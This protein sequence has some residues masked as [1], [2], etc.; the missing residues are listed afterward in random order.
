MIK[1]ELMQYLDKNNLINKQQH[2]FVSNKACNTNLLETIDLLT[3]LLVDKESFDLLLLDFAK[4]FDVVSHQRLLIKLEAYGVSGNLL[5]WL[6]AFLTNR[7]QRVVLG[8]HLSNWVE[9][10]SGVIHGSSLGPIL[11]I[12]YINDLVKII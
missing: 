3:K 7:R 1:D 12:I 4:A 5:L 6:K 8:D 2:G 9:V 10:I 11:F